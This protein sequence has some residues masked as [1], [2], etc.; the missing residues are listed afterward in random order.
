[1]TAS[2]ALVGLAIACLC[3]CCKPDIGDQERLRRA[4]QEEYGPVA[5]WNISFVRGSHHLLIMVKGAFFATLPDSL[6][7]VRAREVVR[8]ALSRYGSSRE[9]DSITL[10]VGEFMSQKE[11]FAYFR[12][13]RSLRLPVVEAR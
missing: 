10:D 3:N 2:R 6:F 5:N 4:L 1:M 8:F 12:V 7:D 9:L 13:G 11:G